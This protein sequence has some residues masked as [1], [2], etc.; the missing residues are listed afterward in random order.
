MVRSCNK[1]DTARIYAIINDAATAYRG[2]IPDDRWHEPYMPLE[3]LEEEIA[4]GIEFWGFEEDGDLVGVMG[5][6]DKGEVTLI[7]HAYVITS[8]R[9]AGIGTRLL[10]HLEAMTDNPILI[11]TWATARWAIRFYEKN[12]YVLLSREETNR[13]LRRFWSIPERQVVTSV[14]LANRKWP[15]Q[16]EGSTISAHSCGES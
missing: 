12:G 11:G 1:S 15:R 6:Q 7:R 2:V 3:E 16:S 8:R 9:H 10:R 14:V 5:I 4:A 13:L